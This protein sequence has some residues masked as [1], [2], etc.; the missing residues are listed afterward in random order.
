MKVWFER[1]AFDGS[2]ACSSGWNF[3]AHIEAGAVSW[4]LEAARS[5]TLIM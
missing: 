1:T 2:L 4:E 5:V 3:L